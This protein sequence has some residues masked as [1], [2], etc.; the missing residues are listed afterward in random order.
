MCR[1]SPTQS[2]LLSYE[3]KGRIPEEAV[4]RVLGN[5][6]T[7]NLEIWTAPILATAPRNRVPP[8]LDYPGN[9]PPSST[10]RNTH[11][12]PPSPLRLAHVGGVALQ[13][14]PRRSRHFA[15]LVEL[16]VAVCRLARALWEW[17]HHHRLADFIHFRHLQEARRIQCFVGSA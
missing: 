5:S 15:R 10:P 3:L 12:Q 16:A 9:N 11:A 8:S 7:I 13:T 14:H 1:V 4:P 2:G 6:Q 17:V